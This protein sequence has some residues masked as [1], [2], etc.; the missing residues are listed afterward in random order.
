M[1]FIP[2]I[3][4]RDSNST[5][6]NYFF[7][8]DETYKEWVENEKWLLRHLIPSVPEKEINKINWNPSVI[9]DFKREYQNFNKWL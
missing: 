1:I 7:K 3:F 5:K 6:V 2:F 8:E 4:Y 9:K